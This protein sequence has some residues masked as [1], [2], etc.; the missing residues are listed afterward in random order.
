MSN[1]LVSILT[2]VY[3]REK[4][5]AACIESVLA[6]CFQ[7]WE[8]IIVDDQSKDNSVA[9]AQQYAAKDRRIY[10]YVNEINLGDYPNR[11]KAATYA[12]GK[13]LKYLDADD[14]I[15]PH[16]LEVM[17]A[18]MEQFSEADFG[19]Q[20]NIRECHQPYPFLVL[21]GRKAETYDQLRLLG[22]NLKLSNHIS[23]TGTL[24][25]PEVKDLIAQS[26]F[27]VFS[28]NLEGCPNG[29]LECM[30]Q[31]KAVVG[32]HISGVE[33]ALGTAYKDIC[34]SQ[35]NNAQDLAN[36]IMALYKQPA[37][38]EEIGEHNRQ[39]IDTE[40]SVEQMVKKHLNLLETVI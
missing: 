24:T 13:Y 6:S 19:T 17:I 16:S 7:D 4:Y 26:L 15:Y 27:G 30:E 21:A 20:Y 28:S 35:P 5:L 14:L 39:R 37:L 11:N 8:M 33:Q 25:T 23:F 2:T 32:T 36:K 12:K 9:I 1:P 31:G 10:V 22:F 38:I 40:F 29:V 18:A 3:N 34:L